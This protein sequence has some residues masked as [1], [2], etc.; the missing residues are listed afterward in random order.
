MSLQEGTLSLLR[1]QSVSKTFVTTRAL[2]EASLAIEEG[3]IR[4]LVG[5]NGSG[6]STLASI[7]SGIITPDSGQMFM[8]DKPHTPKTVLEANNAGI[9]IVVQEMGTIDGLTVAANL[10]L[11]EERRFTKRGLLKTAH[12]NK[13][14]KQALRTFGIENIEPDADISALSFED[15]KLIEFAKALHV[16]PD[17]LIVDETTTALSQRGREILFGELQR[18]KAAKKSIIFISHDLAEVLEHC[19]T[20]TVMKDGVIVDTLPTAG[21][22][23]RKLKELMVGRE[24]QQTYYRE[25][26]EASYTDEVV[27]RVRD[28]TL[29]GSFSDISFDLHS[30]EILGI[31]GLTN[32][33]MHELGK[34]LFGLHAATSGSVE[35]VRHGRKVSNYREAIACGLGYLPKNRDQEGLMLLSSI[36]DNIC[37][38]SLSRLRKNTFISPRKERELAERGAQQL[39]I[40]MSSI[41]Q[42]CLYLSGG[43]KQKVSLSKWLVRDSDILILDC[44]TRGIDVAVKASIYTLMQEL[45]RRGK[46]IV[47]ISEELQ[48]LIGVSDRIMILRRGIVENTLN[49]RENLSEEEI[50]H[51]MI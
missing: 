46:A 13:A 18:L 17:L 42:L 1:V 33:G 31:G 8:Q 11:G 27:L 30:G 14:A 40:K 39:S 25:D 9:S 4:G 32:C 35:A 6:K 43:N 41:N 29:K 28:L 36:K 21:L 20:V 23:E 12:M 37:L 49:R 5:E 48:E 2:R 34:V 7:V 50:I 47:M 51:Y 15:R 22:D 16:G 24:L 3:E 19:D 10:F 26:N 38:P 44:P 45:K